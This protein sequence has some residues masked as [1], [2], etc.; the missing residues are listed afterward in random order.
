MTLCEQVMP[1]LY[2]TV[3]RVELDVINLFLQVHRIVQ[4]DNVQNSIVVYDQERFSIVVYDYQRAYL[5]ESETESESEESEDEV[6]STETE[7]LPTVRIP[8]L[9]STEYP[10]WEDAV[11]AEIVSLGRLELINPVVYIDDIVG[12]VADPLTRPSRF[13]TAENG[14]QFRRTRLTARGNSAPVSDSDCNQQ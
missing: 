13:L 7:V 3:T 4:L 12:A 14:P 6:T 8:Q 9:S 10:R 2:T 1:H 11:R 5:Q